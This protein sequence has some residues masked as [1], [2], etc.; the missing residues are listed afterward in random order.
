MK[1]VLQR[2]YLVLSLVSLSLLALAQQPEIQHFRLPGKAGLN[3][4]EAK[5]TDVAFD[6]LKVRVGGD[7]TL[8]L[9]GL[10]HHND[11]DGAA[12][13]TYDST[14]KLW[15]PNK[16]HLAPISSNFNLPNAN[17]NLDVQL[18]DGLRL[19]MRTYLSARHH[20]EAW[21]K[22]GYMQIDNLNFIKD[23]FLGGFMDIARF[24]FG[25]D[26]FNYGDTHFRRTDNARAIYNPFVGNYIMDAF[27]TEPYAELTLMPKDF[28]VVLGITNGRLNQNVI[29]PVSAVDYSTLVADNGLS[30]YGKAGID[31]Q[32]NDDLRFR[33][34]A[35][36]Y[37]S[38]VNS[39]RDY[40][41]GG[42]RG[43]GRYYKVMDALGVATNDFSGRFNPGFK[44]MTAFTVNPFVKFKGLEF[45]GVYEMANNKAVDAANNNAKIGGGYTQMGA[46]LIY[47][48]AND[49]VY[50]GGRYNSVSGKA[51]D[52]ALET[53]INR[54][55]FGGG[56]FISENVLAKVEYMKQ[57][58][59]GDG[60]ANTVFQGG[61][62]NG[63]VIEATIGF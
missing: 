8:Q 21:I 10:Q 26:E 15:T 18:A 11:F 28:L 25:M 14:T 4:F 23:G 43:G 2:T 56:W 24:T 32:I 61:Y 59:S 22:G 49:N 38:S 19:H 27:S 30:I 35:S 29:V 50:I 17:M 55:N 36:F 37:S 53:A 46:E 13:A 20:N 62:F 9:Q 16:L 44:T 52:V 47:R 48:F 3:V 60:Y 54:I 1:T 63:L 7:F 42:D 12:V 40:L 5:K 57:S 34:T 51:T 31:K 33:L 39:T 58:Y 6:G 41:F 45:F